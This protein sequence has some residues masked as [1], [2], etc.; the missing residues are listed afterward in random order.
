MTVGALIIPPTA[1]V[2]GPYQVHLP[3]T[4]PISFLLPPFSPHLKVGPQGQ[5][6]GLAGGWQGGRRSRWQ[7]HRPGSAT[8][9]A[10][11]V[12]YPEA[13]RQAGQAPAIVL[14]MRPDD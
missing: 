6:G 8:A 1:S 9:A 10:V 11:S 2:A 5:G 7:C 3:V 13:D 4:F 14:G 12:S